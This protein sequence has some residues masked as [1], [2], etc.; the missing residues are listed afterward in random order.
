MIP[1]PVELGC[2]LNKH[3]ILDLR[4]QSKPNNST[5]CSNSVV[6]GRNVFLH[7]IRSS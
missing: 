4:K 1:G 5:S 2:L 3:R 6:K 7:D